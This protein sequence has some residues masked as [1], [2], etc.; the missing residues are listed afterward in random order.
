MQNKLKI[1]SILILSLLINNLSLAQSKTG[2]YMDWNIDHSERTVIPS[3]KIDESEAKV[4]NCYWVEFDAEGRLTSVKYY[5]SG[6]PSD[7]GNVLGTYDE[8]G[9]CN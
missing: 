8:G 2:F 9:H 3:I 7:Y 4:V 5:F 6:N 1:T